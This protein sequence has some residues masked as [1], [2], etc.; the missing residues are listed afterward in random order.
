MIH[1]LTSYHE[2]LLQISIQKTDFIKEANSEELV[3]VL[4]K[5][6]QLMQQIE[7]V[8]SEREAFVT[9]FFVENDIQSEEKTVTKLLTLIDNNEQKQT[10]EQ[11]VTSLIEQ[12]VLIRE[13]EQLNNSLLQHS[14]QFVQLTLEMIQPDSKNIHYSERAESKQTPSNRSVFDSKV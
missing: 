7:Q 3:K 14:M 12:I 6:R 5:E 8:E 9:K 10:I 2:Q 13:R 4:V 1:K 11:A